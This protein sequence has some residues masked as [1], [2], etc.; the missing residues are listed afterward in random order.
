MNSSI[1]QEITAGLQKGEHSIQSEGLV[2]QL[3]NIIET[4]LKENAVYLIKQDEQV[5]FVLGPASLFDKVV[6][7]FDPEYGWLKYI[8]LEKVKTAWDLT[9]R[10]HKHPFLCKGEKELAVSI[11][12]EEYALVR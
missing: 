10:S 5:L 3:S 4:I 6:A 7:K 11:S 2:N 8:Q 1:K 12:P 9:P